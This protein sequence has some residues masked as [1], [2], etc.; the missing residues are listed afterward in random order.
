MNVLIENR[1][2][3]VA[4]KFLENRLRRS[5]GTLETNNGLYIRL[6]KAYADTKAVREAHEA[7]LQLTNGTEITEENGSQ[8]IAVGRR[9]IYWGQLVELKPPPIRLPAPP[10]PSGSV[11]NG[12]QLPD[13]PANY[14]LK[15]QIPESDPPA[16][17]SGF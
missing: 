7:V 4:I 16:T 2:P 10:I 12:Q 1:Q 3:H 11:E 5:D 17:E 6:I 9:P 13:E 14:P 15:S 8:Q